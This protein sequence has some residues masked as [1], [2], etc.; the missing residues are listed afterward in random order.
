MV[1]KSKKDDSVEIHKIM[2]SFSEDNDSELVKSLVK[3]VSIKE[4]KNKV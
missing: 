4:K 2:T 3:S 1:S